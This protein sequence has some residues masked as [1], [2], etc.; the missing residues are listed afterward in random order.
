MM[1]RGTR[2]KGAWALVVG[3]AFAGGLADPL[4]AETPHAPRADASAPV[5]AVST[6]TAVAAAAAT[7]TSAVQV[8]TGFCVRVF[9]YTWTIPLTGIGFTSYCDLCECTWVEDGR[10]YR[11]SYWDCDFEIIGVK[12]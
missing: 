2:S 11:T 9:E 10:L 8:C 12:V 3:W 1:R 5:A 4:G 6:A 7:T